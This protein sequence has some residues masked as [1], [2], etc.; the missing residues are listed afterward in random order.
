MK[1]DYNFILLSLFPVLIIILGFSFAFPLHYTNTTDP[2]Y[3]YLL[4]GLNIAQLKFISG[5]YYHPGI[6]LQILSGLIIKITHKVCGNNTDLIFDVMK[7]PELYINSINSTLLVMSAIVFFI[8]GLVIYKITNSIFLTIF[9]QSAPF[10]DNFGFLQ[11]CL[12]TPEKLVFPLMLIFIVLCIKFIYNKDH[13]KSLFIWFG[14]ITALC[15]M[16]KFTMI[17]FFIAPIIFIPKLKNKLTYTISFTISILILFIPFY[18][19]LKP[20]HDYYQ[21]L[22]THSGLYGAGRKQFMDVQQII[23]DFKI[24]LNE[25]FISVCSFVI[26]L[27]FLP[28]L[29]ILK[30]NKNI[31]SDKIK[32]V[33]I[34]ICISEFL[35]LFSILKHFKSYYVTPLIALALFNILLIVEFLFSLRLIKRH[36]IIYIL[37]TVS[38]F[39]YSLPRV[40]TF[41]Q[42]RDDIK[43]SEQDIAQI[44]NQFQNMPKIIIPKYYGS[45]FKEFSIISGIYFS[46]NLKQY[47]P[48]AKSLFPNTYIYSSWGLYDMNFENYELK[49]VL[50]KHKNFIVS[51]F[52]DDTI[53]L[54]L[55][56]KQISDSSFCSYNLSNIYYNSSSNLCIAKLTNE[57]DSISNDYNLIDSFDSDFE[58]SIKNSCEEVSYSGRKSIKLNMTNEIGPTYIIDHIKPGDI[59]HSS[60]WRYRNKNQSPIIISA[61]DTI[62]F[63]QQNNIPTEASDFWDKLEI[64][65]IVPEK[66]EYDKLKVYTWLQDKTTDAYF[67][68]FSVK[69][70]RKK[71][72]K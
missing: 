41:Y 24:L 36:F 50:L 39:G 54:K 64:T 45:G 6:T 21:A 33:Y 72:V 48:I 58:D 46:D 47:C 17:P 8:L 16:L 52:S 51:Y 44:E 63:F 37:L 60:I 32:W 56:K 70:Y 59:I 71:K 11:C 23:P 49:K 68:C 28:F 22:A 13:K 35:L 42:S 38:F 26:L 55:F 34:G 43:R 57:K 3:F 19:Q 2:E 25:H 61:F 40:L 10:I 69:Q 27:I 15:I 20:M 31:I 12:I 65:I 14:I 29:F 9:L 7:R 5:Y 18:L 30:K 62:Y 67:D 1:R 66:P 4:G 53:L